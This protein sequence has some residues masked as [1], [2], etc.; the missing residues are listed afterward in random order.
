MEIILSPC[1]PA[2]IS[3]YFFPLTDAGYYVAEWYNDTYLSAEA[4]MITLSAG[5][6]VT[7]VNAS[8]ASGGRI[9]G[10]VTGPSGNL[11]NITVR[12]WNTDLS[13]AFSGRTDTSGNY[14]I[15]VP[16]GTYRLQFDPYP[17]RGKIIVNEFYNDKQDMKTADTVTVTA[18][19]TITPQVS[20]QLAAPQTLTISG[21]IRD[22]S[23]ARNL[24]R[25]NQWIG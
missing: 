23:S 2:I 15:P 14:N 5:Q 9:A 4:Q 25:G 6:N 11:T 7:N 18:G 10:K 21:C 19:Q 1:P 20:A 17:G 24:W 13:P 22:G 3:S 16:A 8:L 12:A